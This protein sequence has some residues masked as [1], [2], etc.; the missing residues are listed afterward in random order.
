MEYVD[1]CETAEKFRK[2]PIYLSIYERIRVYHSVLWV[3]PLLHTCQSWFC[4]DMHSWTLAQE[5]YTLYSKSDWTSF[6]ANVCMFY[7][8]RRS[9]PQHIVVVRRVFWVNWS[10]GVWGISQHTRERPWIPILE[11]RPFANV[12]KSLLAIELH[13]IVPLGLMP[14][15]IERWFRNSITLQA[16][17]EINCASAI[18]T[19]AKCCA[20]RALSESPRVF[21]PQDSRKLSTTTIHYPFVAT[22]SNCFPRSADGHLLQLLLCKWNLSLALNN[23]EKLAWLGGASTVAESC[24]PWRWGGINSCWVRLS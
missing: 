10:P 21:S 11:V 16:S 9:F 22:H 4:P 14:N 23:D 3:K 2:Y 19:L 12:H 5:E 7:L 6:K 13:A 24:F 15:L 17:C 8:L 20:F 18:R 1:L